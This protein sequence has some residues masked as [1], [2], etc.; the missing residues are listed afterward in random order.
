ML[1]CSL[2]GWGWGWGGR[3]QAL[4]LGRWR[5]HLK[6]LS[7]NLMTQPSRAVHSQCRTVHS[8]AQRYAP[9]EKKAHLAHVGG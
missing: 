1:S 5:G 4:V 3:G 6:D 9:Q 2:W 7:R 8:H